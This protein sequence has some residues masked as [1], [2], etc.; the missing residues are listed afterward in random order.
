[1][2]VHEALIAV[3]VKESGVLVHIVD[4]EYDTG[5]VIAQTRVPPVPADTPET[6]AARALEREHTVFPET[7]QRFVT[8]E[9]HLTGGS[10]R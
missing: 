2:R 9:L 1:M 3:G 8:G 10:S 7:L 6:P 5:P 4:A